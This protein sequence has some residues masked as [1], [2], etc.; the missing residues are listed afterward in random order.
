M[1]LENCA[2]GVQ[3]KNC[4][5]KIEAVDCDSDKKTMGSQNMTSRHMGNGMVGSHVEKGMVVAIWGGGISNPT[6]LG[7]RDSGIKWNSWTHTR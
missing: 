7:W 2:I 6:H 5:E 3:Y 1:L 4:T